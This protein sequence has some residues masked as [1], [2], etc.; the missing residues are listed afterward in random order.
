MSKIDARGLVCPQPV[1]MAKKALEQLE[2]GEIIT[3]VDNATAK[4]NVCRLAANMNCQYEIEEKEGCFYVKI[5]KMEANKEKAENNDFVIVITTDKLGAGE[6]ELGQLLMKTYTYTLNE[7][8]PYPKAVI[9]INSGV[10]LVVEGSEAL[11]NIQK[12]EEKNIEII[13][14]GT[15]L[16]FYNI[17]DKR[18]VGI[19]GN[20]YTI[21]EYMNN[22]AKV[23]NIC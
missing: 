5:I 18:K 23:I 2:T 17:K 21:V 7:T 19:V 11:E 6:A 1:I 10:K 3:I 9:F 16:D 22:A 14:C 15:C 12:L 13:S 4:E 20:M 8:K